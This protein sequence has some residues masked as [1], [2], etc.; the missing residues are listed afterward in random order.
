MNGNIVLCFNTRS[1]EEFLMYLKKEL[2]HRLLLIYACY[3]CQKFYLVIGSLS[4]VSI[5]IS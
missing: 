1:L 3:Q 4:N 2:I 5:I